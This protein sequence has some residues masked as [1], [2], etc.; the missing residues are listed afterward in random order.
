MVVAKKKKVGK[1]KKADSSL[2]LGMTT[3]PGG[4]TV[5]GEGNHGMT[6]YGMLARLHGFFQHADKVDAIDVWNVLAGL[7]G[8]DEDS[9]VVK[10]STTGVIRQELLGKT[11]TTLRDHIVYGPDEPRFVEVRKQLAY[12]HFREHAKWAFAALGLKWDALND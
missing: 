9:G 1:K 3:Q 8:P 6:A 10:K 5:V 4:L 11:A 7:R 2:A 12:S